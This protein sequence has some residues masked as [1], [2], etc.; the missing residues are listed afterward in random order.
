MLLRRNFSRFA[1]YPLIG[2]SILL[3]CSVFISSP[4][5]ASVAP[6][7][8]VYALQPAD[9]QNLIFVWASGM[10][11]MQQEASHVCQIDTISKSSCV[12]ISAAVRGAWLHLMR[13]DPASLGRPGIRENIAGRTQVYAALAAKLSVLSGGNVAELLVQT[14]QALQQFDTTFMHGSNRLPAGATRYTVWATSFTQSTQTP[15]PDGVQPEVGRYVALPDAYLK[16]ANLGEVADIPSIYQPYYVPNGKSASW[17]VTISLPNGTNKVAKV[18]V[19]D[20]G[21]W[22]EDDNW[23]DANGT[24]NQ[25][26]QSC[27]VSPTLIKPDATSNPL[28]DGICPN[29][30]KNLRRIYY[31]LLYTHDGL[32]FFQPAGYSPSGNFSD[33]NWPTALP[34]GCS[35][36]SNAS[37]NNDGITC[38][39]GADGYNANNGGWLREGNYNSGI[40]NQSSIDLSPAVDKALGWTYPSSGLV[41]VNVGTLP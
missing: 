28:V 26:P 3:L 14:Q 12:A 35:E 37:L 40:S 10:P 34:K 13:V 36:A 23:W 17:A 11:S 38:G 18:P 1:R 33:G 15:L 41:Q 22:N 6:R 21:P 8:S 16:Y 5:N 19:T 4:A 7:G 30:G 39:G 9:M 31:Y 2:L 27:P 25:L 29:N 20:A 24:N 32:P